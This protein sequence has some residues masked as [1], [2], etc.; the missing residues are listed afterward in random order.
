MA[1]PQAPTNRRI[2]PALLLSL[3]LHG[4]LLWGSLLFAPPAAKPPPLIQLTLPPAEPAE[5]L[6]KNTLDEAA[7]NKPAPAPP[8]RT[9]HPAQAQ[10]KVHPATLAAAQR[11]LADHL[12]YPPEAIKAGQEGTVE[13]L[14]TLDPG[15]TVEQA[16]V[17]A[18][19]GYPLLDQAAIRA[20]YAMG[21]VDGAS[22]REML[23]PV[24]FR[25]R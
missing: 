9:P 15:G 21:R 7:V 6:L 12:Y 2:I 17:A 5:P 11:K 23:R 16:E 10:A 24:T 22:H 1:V 25:Q 3:L 4:L 20:A 8:P 18:S 19:S 14:L 13:L